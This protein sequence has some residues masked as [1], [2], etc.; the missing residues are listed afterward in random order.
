VTDSRLVRVLVACY[1]AEW[2]RRYGPE[3]A[4]LLSDS[5]PAASRTG[6]ALNSLRGA[7][8]AHLTRFGVAM[9]SP[10]ATAIW[11]AGLFTA[12]G[13]AFQKLSEH[14][15]GAGV[16]AVFVLAAAVALAGVVAIAVPALI[17]MIRGRTTGAWRYP[18]AAGAAIAA[19]F[20]ML[21][22]TEAVTTGRT[23]AGAVVL[24]AAG[25]GVIATVAWGAIAVLRR[26]GDPGPRRLRPAGLVVL[27]GG[28]A[29]ATVAALVW[30][31]TAQHAHAVDPSHGGLLATSFRLSWIV[32]TLVLAAATAMA[33]SAATHQVA[34]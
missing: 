20:V 8:G 13:I 31:I 11:A 25:L 22:V 5:L 4:A 28:M 24:V 34:R 15:S 23:V 29:A 7:A 6:L 21:F 32:T 2:R 27:A 19:W 18:V 12:G 30:G 14:V 16:R 17:A 1:P 26:A 33:T 9:R 3:Y 10:V